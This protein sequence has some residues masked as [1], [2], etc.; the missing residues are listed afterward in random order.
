MNPTAAHLIVSLLEQHGIRLVAGVGGGAVLP[1]W[2]A[3]GASRQIRRVQARHEQGAGFIAQGVARVTGKPAVC[4]V[5]PGAGVTNLLTALADARLDAVPLVCITGQV[6]RHLIGTGARREVPTGRI[7]DSLTKAS[8]LVR[9]ACELPD[10]VAEALRIAADERPG[11]V[12]LDIPLDV[13]EER[14]GAPALAAAA[15]APEARVE[16]GAAFERVRAVAE[17]AGA[18]AAVTCDL[19]GAISFLRPAHWLT[20]DGLGA[21]GF[22]LPAAIGAALAAPATPVVCVTD[23]DGLLAN[24]QELATLAALELPVRIVLLDRAAPGG[25]CTRLADAFGIRSLD[26][27]GPAAEPALRDAFARPGPCLVRIA[28]GSASVM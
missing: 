9:G 17:L 20:S 15:P 18:G 11:P 14:T 1:L 12:L 25:A 6:P 16:S 8:F 5:G 4:L 19:G 28:P 10:L 24:V 2:D 7:V 27:D 22:A 26:L 21:A 23:N 13:L 3:L